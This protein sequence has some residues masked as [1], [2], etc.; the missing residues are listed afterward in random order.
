MRE[1]NINLLQKINSLLASNPNPAQTSFV[2]AS[3]IVSDDSNMNSNNAIP[4]SDDAEI[5]RSVVII[6]LPEPNSHSSVGRAQ[7]EMFSVNH[8]LSFLDVECCPTAVYRMVVLF[9]GV[10]A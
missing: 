2:I 1:E 5:N 7:M 6:G 10:V 4:N 8:I 3:G 9:R